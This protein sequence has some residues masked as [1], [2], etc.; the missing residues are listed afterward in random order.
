[1]NIFP[2]DNQ[3]QKTERGVALLFVILLT[4]VLLLVAIGIS[5]ISFKE[6]TF[7]LEAR[8][9]DK[10]F[11][12]AD[13]GIECGLYLDKEVYFDGS[14][15]HPYECNSET[16]TVV[17]PTP[18]TYQ[19]IVPLGNQCVEVNADKQYTPP[20]VITD[21]TV[22]HPYYTQISAV[23]YNVKADPSLAPI[24]C[25]SGTMST[26]RIVTRALRIN[27]SNGGDGTTTTTTTTDTG[28]IVAP[29]VET[30]SVSGITSTGATFTGTMSDT[31]GTPTANTYFLV[32]DGVTTLSTALIPNSTGTFTGS[33]SG[34]SPSTAYTFT[35]Q[36]V[37]GTY[38][39]TGSAM[40]FSTTG[41]AL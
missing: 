13:T 6:V 22:D 29:T 14:L 25:V 11:F 40:P 41:P 30:V 38:T 7:S 21:G 35:A 19:F 23:G 27:Y 15:A 3:T 17:S 20:G 37:N 2:K 36:A 24:N 33:I 31:G 9:S 12:A 32:S 39:G 5:N 16:L 4:S 1:M 10:A 28:G 34:L 26:A 18:T 8:D